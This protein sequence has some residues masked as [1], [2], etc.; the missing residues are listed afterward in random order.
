MHRRLCIRS[1]AAL[2]RPRCHTHTLTNGPKGPGE[3]K[4]VGQVIASTDPVA[5]DSYAAK[6]LGKQPSEVKHIVYASA[7]HLGPM[8]LSKVSKSE[9]NFEK[10]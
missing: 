9:P 4:D 1:Q 6:L 2:D 5:I 3:T 7:L 10:G 8:D